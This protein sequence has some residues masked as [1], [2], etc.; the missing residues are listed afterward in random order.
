MGDVFHECS[1][2]FTSSIDFTNHTLMA[3]MPPDLHL[4]DRH[5]DRRQDLIPVASD[6]NGIF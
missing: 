5:C 4:K 1:T 6:Q 3:P 2:S